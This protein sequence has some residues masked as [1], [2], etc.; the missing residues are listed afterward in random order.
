MFFNKVHTRMR[1]IFL[2]FIVIFIAIVFKVFYTQ[3]ISYE[4]LKNLSDSLYSRELPI[5]ADR[6]EILDRNGKALATNITTTSLVVIPKQIKDKE[7]VAR[8]LADILG[9]TYEQMYKHVSKRESIERVHPEGRQLSYEVAEKIE[10]L[11]YDGV[12]LVKESKR[13]YPYDLLLS[14]TLGYVGIDNQ[15][16]SGLELEYDDYLTGLNGAI[17]YFSDGQGNRLETAEVYEGATSGMSLQLT[18]DIDLQ[19]VVENELE[20]IM[21]KY[22]ADNALI[23]VQNPKN[24]EI[25]AMATRPAFN[26]NEYKNYSIEVIN[27][28]LPIWKTYEP[29]STFKN[30]PTILK[31]YS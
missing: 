13:Y 23:L 22:D 7:K 1:V 27:Q 12:Y 16:L 31:I 8:D 2:L 9:V 19:R 15:G 26:P 3:V 5:A 20:N 10:N 4:K 25:L 24:G 18:I 30:I 11:N 29:G 14:H 17:K 28:N 6:G 21:S